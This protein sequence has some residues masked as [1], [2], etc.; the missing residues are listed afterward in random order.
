MLWG[1]PLDRL[2]QPFHLGLFFSL[3]LGFSPVFKYW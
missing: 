1:D 2:D 3:A